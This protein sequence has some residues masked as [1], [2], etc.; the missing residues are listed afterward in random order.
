MKLF[1]RRKNTVDSLRTSRLELVAITP[2]LLHAE[3][4]NLSRLAS[5][6]TAFIPAEWPPAE[7]E[8]HVRA[9][10]ALQCSEKP[11][12]TGWHRYVVLLPSAPPQLRSQL[13]G[14]LGGFPK[15]A[16]EVEIGYSTLPA[17]QRQGFGS[18]AALA[19][20]E[21]L[22]Q[23]EGV[24][25]VTAQ[26]YLG[27]SESLKIMQRCGMLPDGQGDDPGTVRYRRLRSDHPRA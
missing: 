9:M 11:H 18:E 1:G 2:E 13:I 25:A 6:L 20:V 22:L 17:F 14:C 4:S 26:T 23:Q 15:D 8:P 19:F 27:M 24:T 7:W 3:E 12:T 5:L 21:W 10:I 16:G